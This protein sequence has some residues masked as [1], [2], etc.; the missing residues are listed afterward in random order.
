MLRSHSL[1]PIQGGSHWSLCP[2]Q[3]H[4]SLF[5]HANGPDHNHRKEW[6]LH[7]AGPLG[8]NRDECWGKSNLNHLLTST[9]NKAQF[10]Q[11]Q[12]LI[13]FPTHRLP[14]LAFLRWPRYLSIFLSE[15]S[16]RASPHRSAM[17]QTT[18]VARNAP[19]S[20]PSSASKSAREPQHTVPTQAALAV[21]VTARRIS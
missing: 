20:S 12:I 5:G 11:S 17:S 21:T 10:V 18:P 2:L 15:A 7:N 4:H 19:W 14:Q 6:E 16:T 1:T 3:L 8:H 9:C 13:P